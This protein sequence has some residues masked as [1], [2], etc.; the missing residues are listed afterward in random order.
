MVRI[1]ILEC[2]I[3]LNSFADPDSDPYGFFNRPDPDPLLFI[4]IMI[5]PSSSNSKKNLDFY[6]Y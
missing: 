5:L 1:N 4:W 6:C 2:R 3:L